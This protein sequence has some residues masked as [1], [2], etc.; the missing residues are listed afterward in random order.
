[1]R[2]SR[3]TFVL[4]I[5]IC[6]MTATAKEKEDTIPQAPLFCGAAVQVDLAGPIMKAV[7][8][9]YSQLECGARLNFRDHYFPIA[10]F[11]IGESDREGKQNNTQFHT[12]APYFRLGMDYNVNKKHNGNRLFVGVRYA[13]THFKYD[14]NDPD[15]SDPVWTTSESG[16]VLENQ[17]GRMQWIEACVGCETK[18]WSF[19]RLG[20]TLRFKAR[21]HRSVSDYGDPYYTP[22][23]GKNGGTTWGGTCNVIFDVGRTSKKQNKKQ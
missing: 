3:S 11:G 22:G 16:L 20:W 21:L 23:F 1:M 8:A 4:L 15:F 6:C 12:R 7:G 2:I 13:F 18:I 17:K 19:I 10:E 9:K 14:F 5:S